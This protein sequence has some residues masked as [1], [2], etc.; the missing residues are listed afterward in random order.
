VV[1]I[2]VYVNIVKT[3]VVPHVNQIFMIAGAVVMVVKN[4]DQICTI[5]R[6]VVT[7]VVSNVHSD[8]GDVK[9]MVVVSVID[10]NRC[11]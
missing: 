1:A 9:T 7:L 6:I 8:A 10:G 3:M 11:I 5:A 4:V 2:I